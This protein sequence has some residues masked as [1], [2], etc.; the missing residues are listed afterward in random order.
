[1]GHEQKKF[2]NHCSTSF[3]SPPLSIS[4]G[5]KGTRRKKRGERPNKLRKESPSFLYSLLWRL[6]ETCRPLHDSQHAYRQGRS[7][8]TAL[9]DVQG[10]IEASLLKRH[11]ITAV[12]LDASGAFDNIPYGS[13]TKGLR[14]IGAS[15]LITNWYE[16]LLQGRKIVAYS[17]TGMAECYPTRGTP[18]GGILSPLAWNASLNTLLETSFPEGIKLTAYA[19]DILLLAE[20][21]PENRAR[22]INTSLDIISK[23]GE[24]NNIVFNPDKTR[25]VHFSRSR[26]PVNVPP[27]LL[28]GVLLTP[29]DELK[30]L[31]VIFDKK[32][33]FNDHCMDRVRKAK[34]LLFTARR[35]VNRTWGITPKSAYW[36]YKSI[37]LPTL[38]YGCHTWCANITHRNRSMLGKIQRLSLLLV[39]SAMKGTP[40]KGMEVIIGCLPLDLQILGS[41]LA[42]LS[43][44]GYKA[45]GNNPRTMRGKLAQILQRIG[46][47]EISDHTS[48]S[49]WVSADTRHPQQLSGRVI[50]IYTDG[51]VKQHGAGCA[52]LALE[53][54]AVTAGD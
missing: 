13:I 22:Q 53:D 20:G 43:R 48:A 4:L 33:L 51:S 46:I 50:E 3:A 35:L 41:G 6:Q 9:A 28:S 34:A 19:D 24:A 21:K 23:W 44:I 27:V 2:G 45:E 16:N 26:R 25:M 12:S 29:A 32:L 14:K 11:S 7:C 30:F 36:I 1:L 49:W 10:R 15:S 47:S 40:T 42:T 54:R 8:D 17:G 31:G 38:T 5:P 52:W 18:Q 39:T 37:I